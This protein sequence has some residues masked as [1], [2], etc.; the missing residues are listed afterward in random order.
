[1]AAIPIKISDKAQKA[2]L[3]FSNSIMGRMKLRTPRRDRMELIDRKYYMEHSQRAKKKN[4]KGKLDPT[5]TPTVISHTETA[6]TQLCD[7]FLSGYPIFAPLTSPDNQQHQDALVACFAKQEKE[8]GWRANLVDFFRD[9]VKYNLAFVETDWA[10]RKVNGLSAEDGIPIVNQS[11]VTGNRLKRLDPYNTF[12]DESV[13]ADEL[14]TYGQYAGYV[15][16]MTETKLKMILD[17]LDEGEDTVINKDKVFDCGSASNNFYFVPEILDESMRNDADNTWEGYFGLTEELSEDKENSLKS[18]YEVTTLYVRVEP[19]KLGLKIPAE[20]KVQI[21]KIVM[22]NYKVVVSVKLLNNIHSYLPILAA[23]VQESKLK[24]QA[25][26]MAE[27]IIPLQDLVTDMHTAR[28][29]GIKRAVSDRIVYDPK[30][31]RPADINSPN[32]AS[33]IAV[34]NRGQ[35]TPLQSLIYQIPYRDDSAQFLINEAGIVEGYGNRI[36]G[37]NPAAQGQHIPGNKTVQEFSTI[38]ANAS[39]RTIIMSIVLEAGIFS[40]LKLMVLNN[41]VQYQ[42]QEKYY[43]TDTRR[44]LD[45]NPID[46]RRISWDFD[47]A[48]GSLPISKL[49]NTESWLQ[50]L[51]YMTQIP[52]LAQQYKVAQVFSYVFKLL[53]VRGMSAFE[54]TQ[55]ELLA[56]QQQQLALAQAQ[57]GNSP[58]G[59]DGQG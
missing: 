55:E 38:M 14:H 22:V 58:G 1:M 57:S 12:Y 23:S 28:L 20:D 35:D 39:S 40:P 59:N 7:T 17:N 51:G 3:T 32:P 36:T 29:A 52:E 33:K 31:I 27:M 44:S 37:Q 11:E 8:W 50:L 47:V 9:C 21:F 30:Y 15:E 13:S 2:I 42:E 45:Y 5:V 10:T 25:K 16:R 4:L 43:D 34:R 24:S 49:A 54:K 46:I 26:S 19:N 53:G 56:E 18:L 41:T 48:D 6:V